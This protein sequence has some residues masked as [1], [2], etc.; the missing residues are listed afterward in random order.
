M[1]DSSASGPQQAAGPSS[2]SA[3]ASA[4][5]PASQADIIRS[6]QKDEFYVQLLRERVTEL[7]TFAWGSRESARWRAEIALLCDAVYHGC[8]TVVSASQTLGEEFCDILPVVSGDGHTIPPSSS[9]SSSSSAQ[10]GPLTSQR[11]IKMLALHVLPLYILS[12]TLRA[13]RRA[14]RRWREKSPLWGERARRVH[15]VLAQL[16][17]D[18]LPN[19]IRFHVAWFFLRGNFLHVCK[20]VAGV[21]YVFVDRADRPRSAQKMMATLLFL[22]GVLHLWKAREALGI[23]RIISMMSAMGGQRGEHGEGLSESCS[24]EKG[25]RKETVE[26]RESSSWW[27]FHAWVGYLLGRSGGKGGAQR[28][29]RRGTATWLGSD[30]GSGTVGETEG[31]VGMDDSTSSEFVAAVREFLLLG[32]PEEG[33]QKGGQRGRADSG[34]GG[35]SDGGDSMAGEWREAAVSSLVA[36]WDLVDGGDALGE[37]EGGGRGGRQGEREKAPPLQAASCLFCL[38]GCTVPTA[39]ACGHVFCWDC[40]A[41]WCLENPS[42]PICRAPSPP[43]QLLSLHHYAPSRALTDFLERREKEREKKIERGRERH[44]T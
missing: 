35:E 36:P 13:T 11:G 19:L 2:A 30:K 29:R 33:R 28:P 3:S 4:H 42:C 10:M 25:D 41:P 23:G 26:S 21:R 20:R 24:R 7:V 38:G 34:G 18:I 39:T 44:A 17:D 15:T 43:Q 6:A 8:C 5:P 16:Q 31:G 1:V 40:V 14:A 9:S 22:Q 32:G 12:R 27:S 37:G